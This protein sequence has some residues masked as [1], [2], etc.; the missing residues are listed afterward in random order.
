MTLL[1]FSISTNVSIIFFF[2]LYLLS[3]TV[4]LIILKIFIKKLHW[5]IIGKIIFWITSAFFVLF[6][7]GVIIDRN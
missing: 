6:F 7:I 1:Q 5:H 3:L 2:I 4:L